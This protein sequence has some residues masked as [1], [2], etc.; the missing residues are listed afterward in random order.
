MAS[1]DLIGDIRDGALPAVTWVQPRFPVSEHPGFKTNSTAGER[2]SAAVINAVMES[3]LWKDTA[4]FLT[5]DEWGGFYDHVV[6]PKVDQFGL[7]IRVPM[8]VISPY[9]RRGL[10]TTSAG[11]MPPPSG[12]SNA[13]GACPR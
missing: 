7:G 1:D 13:I 9:A 6:P 8:V 10:S 5:W 11:S 4:I 12:S 2:W 3:P